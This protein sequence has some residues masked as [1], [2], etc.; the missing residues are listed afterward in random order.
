MLKAKILDAIQ[1]LDYSGCELT[2]ELIEKLYYEDVHEIMSKNEYE[3]VDEILDALPQHVRL[4][5]HLVDLQS[6]VN[7]DSLLSLFYNHSVG[8]NK[9]LMEYLKTMGFSDLAGLIEKAQQIILTKFPMPGDENQT[10]TEHKDPDIETYDYFGDEICQQIEEIEE[11]DLQDLLWGDEFWER[12]R[13]IWNS[14]Q[15]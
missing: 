13:E 12:V 9:R 2:D 3:Q 6:T 4:V 11:N 14:M 1:Q 8:E 5:Y 15:K 7:N 10:F